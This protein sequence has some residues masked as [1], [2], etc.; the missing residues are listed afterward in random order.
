MPLNDQFPSDIPLVR[1][2]VVSEEAE[3]RVED[4]CT[5]A[6][7]ESQIISVG[8]LLSVAGGCESESV[9]FEEAVGRAGLISETKT[10]L[11]TAEIPLC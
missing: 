9:I 2:V 1:E 4:E 5:E 7:N 11:D 8:G 6:D 10:A 3:R